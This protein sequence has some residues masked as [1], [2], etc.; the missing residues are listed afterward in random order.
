MPNTIHLKEI[1]FAGGCFWGVEEYYSRIP[2][3]Y[4]VTSG[5]ANGHTANPSYEEVCTGK[6]GHAE[7]VR[8][9]YDPATITLE[10][11]AHQF[12]KIINPLSI[13][14]QGNDIGT[15]YRTGIYYV[16]AEDRPV[17]ESVMQ[18]IQK[19]YNQPLAV[20][21][22]PLNHFYPAEAYHQEYL[23]KNPQGYCHIN[24][25]SLKDFMPKNKR[26]LDISQYQKPSDEYLKQNLS[27]QAYNVTQLANT[28]RA[29]TGQYWDH[30]VP[31]IYV[32]IVTGEPLF[33]SSDKYDSG[34]G[35]P[36]FTR[37]IDPAV[38]IEKDDHSYGM[39][40]TEVQSRSGHSHLGH[41]FNDGPQDQGGLRYC[42]NSAAL[43]FIPYEEMAQQGYGDFKPLV[44][45]PQ[46]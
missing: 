4:T 30:K 5:Y 20:E 14:Q 24:F 9:Q 35:W 37:P 29:F 46:N 45:L 13:N 36:S 22:K 16:D 26:V 12:F 7:T 43:R 6:T 3:V 27:A 11:L 10:Q 44:H 1:Y 33:S 41:V 8:V 28:E 40:R 42:I 32:D 2:G 39:R 21:L 25:D 31:G 38:I 19:K 23:K 34:C 17:L 18:E 15:Q